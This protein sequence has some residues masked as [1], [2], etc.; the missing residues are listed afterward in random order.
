MF[1]D[2]FQK[3]GILI[4]PLTLCSIFALTLI[5]ERFFYLRK[6]NFRISK[7]FQLITS[8]K[9]SDEIKTQLNQSKSHPVFNVLLAM[10]SNRDFDQK[11]LEAVA[12]EEAEKELQRLQKN[13]RPLGV[14]ATLAPLMGLLGTVLGIMKAFLMT[15][16]AGKVDPVLLA[17]GIWEALI[18]TCVG[19]AIA[20]PCWAAYYYFE[21]RIEKITFMMEYYSS[22]FLRFIKTVS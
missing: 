8:Q 3:G 7:W 5:L 16:E 2:Y 14:I 22:K 18:T 19:L 15:A 6:F 12:L 11:A 9:S 10:W 13:L 20:I 4:Y 17:G 1:L 21:S